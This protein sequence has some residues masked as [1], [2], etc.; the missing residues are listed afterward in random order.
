[1]KGKNE[2]QIVDQLAS[3]SKNRKRSVDSSLTIKRKKSVSKQIL[4]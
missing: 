4:T 3:P 1:M 2:Y